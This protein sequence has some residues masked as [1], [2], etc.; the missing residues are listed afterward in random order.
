MLK[1][2]H[3]RIDE[4]MGGW[5]IVNR[6]KVVIFSAT[7]TASI[8]GS[9]KEKKVSMGKSARQRHWRAQTQVKKIGGI[10]KKKKK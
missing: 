1:I 10:K 6:N 5:R 3:M 2:K 9:P 4:R 8:T 7:G